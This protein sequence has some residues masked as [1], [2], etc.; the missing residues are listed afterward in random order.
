MRITPEAIKAE[1]EKMFLE[2]LMFGRH[3]S[4]GTGE[5]DVFW[6]TVKRNTRRGKCQQFI[7]SL[8]RL[9]PPQGKRKDI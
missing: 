9:A 8:R 3:L 5:S 1:K 7:T 2:R 6:R 4:V